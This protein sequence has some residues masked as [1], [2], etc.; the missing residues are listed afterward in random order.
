MRSLHLARKTTGGS[1]G[2]PERLQ[3]NLAV[4]SGLSALNLVILTG[5]NLPGKTARFLVVAG[6][7]ILGCLD[8]ALGRKEKEER[9]EI[10]HTA[11]FFSWVMNQSIILALLP[12]NY[13]WTIRT[14]LPAVLVFLLLGF[15]LLKTGTVAVFLQDPMEVLALFAALAGGEMSR[16]LLGNLS[17]APVA[18]AVFNGLILYILSKMYMTGYW[19][20]S[21]VLFAV[22]STCS[23]FLLGMTWTG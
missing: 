22:T 4:L 10:M 16:H 7:L 3:K 11:L 8:Y 14:F 12:G 5:T 6:L 1:G 19:K 20:R 23:L 17:P 2:Q 15:F 9:Y 18:L 21:P 13:L